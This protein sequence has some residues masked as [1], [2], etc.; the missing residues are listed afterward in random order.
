[1]PAF[2]R[3]GGLHYKIAP[4]ELPWLR[5]VI[6]LTGCVSDKLQLAPPAGVDFSGHWKLNEADS[7]D[8][9]RLV[10]GQFNTPGGQNT[11]GAGGTGGSGGGGRRGRRGGGGMGGDLGGYP[12]PATP[13]AGLVGEGLRWPGKDLAIKQVAGVVAFTSEGVNRVCQPTNAERK[14]RHHESSDEGG[15]PPRPDSRSMRGDGPPPRCGWDEKTLIVL[16]GDAD[17]DRPPFEERYSIS[18]DG[19]RLVEVVGFKSGRSNGFAMSRVWTVCP[20]KKAGQS[21]AFNSPCLI[22]R[23]YFLALTM[24]G[25]FTSL[26]SIAFGQHSSLEPSSKLALL[27]R[28]VKIIVVQKQ[29]WVGRGPGEA[30]ATKAQAHIE[31]P[32]SRKS[33]KKPETFSG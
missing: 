6:F 23:A 28:S 11:A 20:N 32:S 16:G 27:Q 9:Q 1:M 24:I 30:G 18:G 2:A 4:C 8:P 17:E 33:I 7:D 5:R 25:L 3:R 29:Q 22:C 19:Q 13:S 26:A 12:G 14:P 10:Q 15:R 31:Y 21:P